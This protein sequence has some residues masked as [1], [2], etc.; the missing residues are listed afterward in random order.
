MNL[1]YAE[2]LAAFAVA[3]GREPAGIPPA[4]RARAAERILD[5][6]GCM[7]FG[8]DVPPA[9]RTLGLAIAMGAGD[10][11][12][13]GHDRPTSPTAA[14]FAHGTL[15]QSFELNDLGVYCHPGACV[16]PAC[17]SA[18]DLVAGPVPGAR[19]V[20]AVV[21]GYEVMIRL[22]ECVGPS[23][24][25]DVGW[26]TPAFHGAVGAAVAAGVV[27][28]FDAVTMAQ[29]IVIA[30][31]YA[32]GGLM[33]ARLGT[34][35]KR[36]H[37]GRA[38]E[39]GVFAALL[40]QRGIRSRL[41]TLE[42][43]DWGYCRTMTASTDKFDL[44][45][46]DR[47]LGTRYIAFDRTGVKYYPVGAEV[48]GAID[49]VNLLK[50]RHGIVP[51]A[52][53]QV[54]VGTPRFFVTAQG[55]EFP[56]SLSQIHFNMEYGVAM[57][58]VHD[59]RPVY[60]SGTVLQQWLQGYAS[61]VVRLLAAR[62]RHVVDDA[63]DRRNPYGIDSNVEIVLDDGTVL[64]AG[65][66]YVAAAESRGTMQ[67][68]PMEADRIQ[69]KFVVLAGHRVATRDA[70]RLAQAVLGLFDAADATGLWRDYAGAVGAERPAF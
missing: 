56:R 46:L 24:E 60:E 34:D 33:M 41:D 52:V 25:L 23:A 50:A 45:H 12:V 27:L 19:F 64:A 68:A 55:H 48:L 69:A 1:T 44:D 58:L 70:A 5:N 62:V 66:D 54:T 3:L 49:N 10:C 39:T 13:L 59:V 4:V 31:D 47:D 32:G 53:R 61:D 51:A 20:A 43:P 11:R 57:A 67:F 40:A 22:S 30:A 35:V 7:T 8:L 42:H 63:L 14:A 26:H 6:L 28:G 17:L 21:A 29:A 18:L 15:A 16:V 37:C 9:M 2:K 38:A 65:T 36:T